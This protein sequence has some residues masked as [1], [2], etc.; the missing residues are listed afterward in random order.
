LIIKHIDLIGK[1][2]VKNSEAPA[3]LIL[4]GELPSKVQESQNSEVS[5][6]IGLLTP[7]RTPKPTSMQSGIGSGSSEQ[8]VT[9]ATTSTAAA[10]SLAQ[11]SERT[12]TTTEARERCSVGK[13]TYPQ[14]VIY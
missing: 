10:Q 3:T 7:E 1:T 2:T 4:G 13:A 8:Q 12:D 9:T 11:L 6:K 5:G 14:V